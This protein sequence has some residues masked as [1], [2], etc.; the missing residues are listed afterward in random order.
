MDLCFS[1]ICPLYDDQE[2]QGGHGTHC[3]GSIAGSRVDGQVRRSEER[4]DEL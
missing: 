1:D 3:A 4:S 2:E